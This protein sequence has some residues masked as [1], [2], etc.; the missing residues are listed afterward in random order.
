HLGQGPD[1]RQERDR[2]QPVGQISDRD[3]DAAQHECYEEQDIRQDERGFGAQRVGQQQGD[4]AES[5]AYGGVG[6]NESSGGGV[7]T[8]SEAQRDG[9][10][11]QQDDLGYRDHRDD[12]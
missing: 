6:R 7:R 5:R 3:E 2:S 4:A 12:D 9:Q 1:G 8:G 10:R 11:D